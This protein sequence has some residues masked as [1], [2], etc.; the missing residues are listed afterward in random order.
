MVQLCNYSEHL[1]RLQ[2]VLP[3]YG[4]VILGNGEEEHFRLSDYMAYY[5]H[6]K[7]AF[8]RY[9]SEAALDGIEQA[10]QYPLKVSHCTYCAWDPACE[11]QRRADDHLSFVAWMR[12]DQIAK[13]QT[14]GICAPQRARAS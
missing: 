3:G 9:V 12:N 8:L 10:R 11:A 6:L 1:E 5:R 13:L 7:R 14:A 2:G 4:Y